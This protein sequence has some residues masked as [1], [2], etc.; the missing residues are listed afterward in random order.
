[1]L[2]LGV[3]FLSVQAYIDLLQE[4]I[5]LPVISTVCLKLVDVA[6]DTPPT[7][8]PTTTADLVASVVAVVW[9]IA[10]TPPAAAGA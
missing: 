6:P 3:K 7:V 10:A 9:S 2:C 4:Y 1:M 8:A 5:S